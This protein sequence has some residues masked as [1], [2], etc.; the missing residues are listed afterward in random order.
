MIRI[1]PAR[2]AISGT[3]SVPYENALSP[4]WLTIG[5]CRSQGMKDAWTLSRLDEVQTLR[6]Q[7]VRTAWTIMSVV[8]FGREVNDDLPV[9]QYLT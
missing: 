8:A 7:R 6:M 5:L 3:L 2:L 4:K 1:L 9:R